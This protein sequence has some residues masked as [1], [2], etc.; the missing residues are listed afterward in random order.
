MKVV[1]LCFGFSTVLLDFDYNVRAQQYPRYTAALV[2]GA[3]TLTVLVKV[4]LRVSY[5]F[6]AIRLSIETLLLGK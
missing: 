4:N 3:Q 1:S 5:W 6:C 2:K